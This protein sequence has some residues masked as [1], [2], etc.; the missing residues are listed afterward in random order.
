MLSQIKRTDSWLRLLRLQLPS[1]LTNYGSISRVTLSDH[2]VNGIISFSEGSEKLSND[3]TV[4]VKTKPS[5]TKF[6]YRPDKSVLGN[7]TDTRQ[8]QEELIRALTVTMPA[9]KA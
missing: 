1:C 3:A 2:D 5:S 6:G 8:I 4:F 9:N 7:E